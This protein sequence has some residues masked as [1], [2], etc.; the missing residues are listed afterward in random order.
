[1][2][3]DT[4]HFPLAG[5]PV[6]DSVGG[7]RFGGALARRVEYNGLWYTQISADPT[8]TG[9]SAIG[10]ALTPY[11]NRGLSWN[12]P[13]GTMAGGNARGNNS[14]D[15]SPA[16]TLADDVASGNKA[17][18]IGSFGKST[19]TSSVVL[20]SGGPAL[21]SADGAVAIGGVFNQTPTASA[22]NAFAFGGR[23][24]AT[25]RGATAFGTDGVTQYTVNTTASGIM[26]IATGS[27]V[28]ADK[29]GQSARA[30]GVSFVAQWSTMQLSV[31][32]A[33]A[34]VTEM[35]LHGV[36]S[37][38]MTL[39]ASTTWMADLSVVARSASGTDNACFKRRCIIKRDAAN[40]TALVSTVQTLD[41]DIASAGAAAWA[42]TVTADD[43]N[44][45]LKIEVT[46][47]AAT[48]IRWVAKVDLVE[49]GYA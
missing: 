9:Q 34:T 3:L 36:A 6:L 49:V 37:N 12:V 48:N 8:D 27:G 26:S 38:R 42:V 7:A 5:T 25:A 35:F 46:G 18:L 44:E 40:N 28:L 15:L 22:E 29:Y 41:T 21:A 14:I 43:T 11:G 13:D 23:A 30:A 39:V 47:A 19:G 20:G 1:M 32:T 4:G 17:I 33:D 10:L 2:A 16:R 45:A 31:A 24:N